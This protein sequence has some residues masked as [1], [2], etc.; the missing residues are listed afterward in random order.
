MAPACQLLGV[1][2]SDM[3]PVPEVAEI[4]SLA[5]EKIELFHSNVAKT[6]ERTR[7]AVAQPLNGLKP[8]LCVGRPLDVTRCRL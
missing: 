2:L 5:N 6:Y 4:G 8:P 3:N 1:R 7:D